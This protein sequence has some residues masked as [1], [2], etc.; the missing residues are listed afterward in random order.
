[1]TEA[2]DAARRDVTFK[3]VRNCIV[4]FHRP[5]LQITIVETYRAHKYMYCFVYFNGTVYTA[6]RQEVRCGMPAH[7]LNTWL[8]K[9]TRISE[10]Q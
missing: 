7:C 10:K 2:V 5:D 1:M 4:V 8:K 3:L 9:E 6:G